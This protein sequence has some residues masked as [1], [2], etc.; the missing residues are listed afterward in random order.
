MRKCGIC[1]TELEKIQKR[2]CSKLC[3]NIGMKKNFN[4]KWK[5]NETRKMRFCLG[6]YCKG[7]KK[8]R[9][10]GITD[11]ICLRCKSAI[12]EIYEDNL[13]RSI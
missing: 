10:S 4:A 3:A 11:R 8:F 12:K 9:S 1:D 13:I 5:Q 6:V 7:K 2:F